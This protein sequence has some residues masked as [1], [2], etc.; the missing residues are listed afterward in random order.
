M[1]ERLEAIEVARRLHHDPQFRYDV[2]AAIEADRGARPAREKRLEHA[3]STF[4]VGEENGQVWIWINGLHTYGE[5]TASRRP[6]TTRSTRSAT[7]SRSCGRRA[8]PPRRATLT[9][10]KREADADRRQRLR[11]LP[12]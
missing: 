2:E 12:R 6:T 1:G 5:G 4:E 8:T 7:R 10:R 9:R 11:S 3:S